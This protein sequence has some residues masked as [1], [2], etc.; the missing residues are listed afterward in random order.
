[1]NYM[2][3][4][5]FLQLSFPFRISTNSTAKWTINDFREEALRFTNIREGVEKLGSNQ[6]GNRK[7]RKTWIGS[8][9][10]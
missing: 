10:L 5:H 1:M 2:F 7:F 9:W 4:T 8:M 3:I 6:K